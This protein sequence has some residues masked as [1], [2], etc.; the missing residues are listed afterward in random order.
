[1]NKNYY[2]ERLEG[3]FDKKIYSYE[4][5]PSQF[6]LKDRISITCRTHG[7]FSAIAENHLNGKQCP[8]CVRN[9]KN[10]HVSPQSFENFKTIFV[11]DLYPLNKISDELVN[12]LKH[13]PSFNKQFN[14]F[15][16]FFKNFED[17]KELFEEY[18]DNNPN[19][20]DTLLKAKKDETQ[21]LKIVFT[22]KIMKLMKTN[23]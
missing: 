16:H 21:K 9:L 1:M 19:V 2:I 3:L 23:F 11:E 6:D 18:H 13:A 4:K 5:L 15:S 8:E 10:I 14:H 12:N 20:I 17:V 22:D 7:D